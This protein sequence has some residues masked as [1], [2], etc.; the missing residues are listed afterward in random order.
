MLKLDTRLSPNQLFPAAAT[1][2]CY[3][4][5][6]LSHRFF[7]QPLVTILGSIGGD[8]LKALLVLEYDFASCISYERVGGYSGTCLPAAG[9]DWN[10]CAKPLWI[11]YKNLD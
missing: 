6:S 2:P 9:S 4:N 3:I 10:T 7:F 1:T 5:M 8:R 11:I